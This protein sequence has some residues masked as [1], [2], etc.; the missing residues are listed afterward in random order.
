MKNRDNSECARENKKRKEIT[1]G[2]EKTEEKKQRER[3]RWVKK[4]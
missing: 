4:Q 2:D 3:E 1:I